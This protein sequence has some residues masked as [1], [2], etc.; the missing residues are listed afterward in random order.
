MI[1]E[2][3]D[4]MAI[5]MDSSCSGNLPKSLALGTGRKHFSLRPSCWL[6]FLYQIQAV[7]AHK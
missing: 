4:S 6:G 5:G 2:F 1:P 7:E 3:A